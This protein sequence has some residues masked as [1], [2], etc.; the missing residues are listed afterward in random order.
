MRGKYPVIKSWSRM[1]P[2]NEILV[3][4]N[5]Q[6]LMNRSTSDFDFWNVDRNN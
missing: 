2:A 4:F 3:F 5:S 1:P 6:Y